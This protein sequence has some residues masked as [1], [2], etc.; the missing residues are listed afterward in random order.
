MFKIGWNHSSIMIIHDMLIDQGKWQPHF[1]WAMEINYD[2]L[3]KELWHVWVRDFPWFLHRI[4]FVL[5]VY[6]FSCS[7][8]RVN[9]FELISFHSIFVVG[10]LPSRHH[11]DMF[12]NT[13]R[14]VLKAWGL[15][16]QTPQ[17]ECCAQVLKRLQ[18]KVVTCNKRSIVS[19]VST[20][21]LRSRDNV[22]SW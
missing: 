17:L 16:I 12:V 4:V 5:R 13:S 15:E 22:R 2:W 10:I 18:A 3:V 21:P 11:M 14:R 19:T 7:Q 6:H 8:H 20:Q 1:T 9:D